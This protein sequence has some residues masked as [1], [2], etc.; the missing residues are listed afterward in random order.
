M[1]TEKEDR[2][3]GDLGSGEPDE[4]DRNMWAPEDKDE[5]EVITGAVM[6][7]TLWWRLIIM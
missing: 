4:L 6:P 5:T 1:Q 3:M 7:D 2:E